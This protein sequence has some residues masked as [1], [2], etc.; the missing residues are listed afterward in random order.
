MFN[1]PYVLEY[2]CWYK[3]FHGD[4]GFMI[5][6]YPK[7]VLTT[8]SSLG[9]CNPAPTPILAQVCGGN[10]EYVWPI[11]EQG[12]NPMAYD[13]KLT[14]ASATVINAQ[15]DEGKQR[16]Y[17]LSELAQKVNYS[18]KD[19]QYKKLKVKFNLDASKYP[20]SSQALI[21]TF[22]NGRFTVDQT[23]V[24]AN[25]K[26]FADTEDRDPDDYCDDYV[27]SVFY[28]IT[29]TDLPVADRKGYDAAVTSYEKAKS[30]TKRAII[31]KS[32]ADGLQALID[33]ETWTPPAIAN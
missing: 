22:K 25:T 19:P 29:F 27:A 33:L 32:P 16:D 15:S 1:K 10:T 24:D 13:T 7:D 28:G 30:D 31:V 14:T 11:K 20:L 17:L 23:K 18:W 8:T 26:F 5:D 12:N 21:D 2:D 6:C 9:D 3:L 4:T